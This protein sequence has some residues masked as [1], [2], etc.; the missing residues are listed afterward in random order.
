LGTAEFVSDGVLSKVR[1]EAKET[2]FVLEIKC[3]I[4]EVGTEAEQ[5]L[6][7]SSV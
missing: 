1:A 7:T 3:V 6:G 4:C 5:K 2:V